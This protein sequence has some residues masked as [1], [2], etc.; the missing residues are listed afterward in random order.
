MKMLFNQNARKSK[1]L[2]LIEHLDAVAY[3]I[4]GLEELQFDVTAP[5]VDALADDILD[6]QH[7]LRLFVENIR[8]R[9]LSLIAHVDRA[10][11]QAKNLARF[12]AG[13]NAYARL[14]N[15]GTQAFAD[16]LAAL[17]Q[18]M[19]SDF[20]G[21]DQVLN[22]LHARK[23]IST[24]CLSVEE[25]GVISPGADYQISGL[26][27]MSALADQCASFLSLLEE[28]ELLADFAEVKTSKVGYLR[29]MAEAEELDS[30]NA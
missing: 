26:V 12:D 15:G 29:R 18:P 5:P 30:L 7:D 19:T 3:A 11:H 23:L 20:D 22:F 21:N 9:E 6:Y 17:G 16:Q 2:L 27:P 25:T 24:D 28:H 14:F 13:I 8:A 1:L 10:R 4:E